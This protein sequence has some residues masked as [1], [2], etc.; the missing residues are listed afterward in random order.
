MD[1]LNEIDRKVDDLEKK[2][3]EMYEDFESSKKKQKL[4]F[5]D[6]VQELIGAMIIALPFSLTEEVWELAKRLSFLRVLVVYLIT[7]ITVFLFIK[8]SKL[9]NWEHQNVL[10]FI[11]LRLI[12]S[13]SI[14]FFIS[15]LFLTLFG[16]YPDM[17]KDFP[18]LL[19]ASLL[20]SIFAVIGSLGVDV[21][22]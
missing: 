20:V 16:V 9:Q 22:K 21:A 4:G 17:I 11:P 15:L 5:S 18:T 1:K 19:K 3:N 12:T 14:S 8:Y 10:G 13:L 7:V 2:I 6:L